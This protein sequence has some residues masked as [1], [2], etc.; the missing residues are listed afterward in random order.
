MALKS[1]FCVALAASYF[2]LPVTASQSP[3]ASFESRCSDLKHAPQPSNITP[4]YSEYIPAGTNLVVPGLDPS[5]FN[6]TTI[7]A[8]ICRLGLNVTT[9]DR[10]D[11]I[12]EVWLPRNWTRRF[13]STGNGGINGCIG[14][15]DM[16][17]AT[18]LGF[19][20]TGSNNGHSG[21]N[22]TRFLNNLEVVIDYSY[23]SL[24]MSAAI[25]K[26]VTDKFYGK[27]HQK[28]Y[29]LGCSTGGRQGF[30]MAQEFPD[31][32]DGIVAGAPAFNFQGLLSWSGLFHTIIKEVGPDGVPPQSSWAA[33]DAEILAQCDHLDGAIDGIL[34]D[35]SLCN[36]RPEALICRSGA[37]SS[38]CLTGKQADTVRR[39][40]SPVNGVNGTF[41]YP[42]AEPF[43]GIVGFVLSIYAPE[44]FQYTDHWF[45]YAVY[46]DSNLNTENLGPEQW[47]YAFKHDPA[48]VRTYSGDLTKLRK[49]GA[50][51][52]HYHGLEDPLISSASSTYYYNLASRTM[53]LASADLD[54]F[55]R[56]FRISG[57]SHCLGGTGA[58]AIGNRGDNMASRDPKANVLTAMIRWVEEGVAPEFV[59][60]A[61][62]KDPKTPGEVE[63]TRR[64][65][66][67]PL[68]NV[69]KAGGKYTNVDDWQCVL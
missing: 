30:K 68:R 24:T 44:Q 27:A 17:Y 41:V 54:K 5:C 19:A 29:Y 26:Q 57:M 36:F 58:S 33:I 53:S 13:L 66:K 6:S 12:M 20:A 63:Y 61:K 65:C 67:Y 25:G 64:H 18:Q 34:E 8:D 35:P 46:N 23:R 7:L 37:K 1:S 56:Y 55:Y 2:S 50:K 11:F 43:S 31:I 28:S 21:Q 39:F 45:K 4:L 42:R 32:F 10:S 3:S 15:D 38:T 47:D 22:G 49:R 48:N 40:L 51:L 69:L 52:L 60:G 9:S 59:T 14:Y 62:F 16:T